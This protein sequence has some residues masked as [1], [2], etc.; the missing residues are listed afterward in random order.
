LKRK[1]RQEKD[2]TERRRVKSI[3]GT[4]GMKHKNYVTKESLKQA[5]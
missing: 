1:L 4:N 3:R 5:I 2:A